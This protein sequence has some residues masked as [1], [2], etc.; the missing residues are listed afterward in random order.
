M[1]GIAGGLPH[2]LSPGHKSSIQFVSRTASGNFTG[3]EGQ[4]TAAFAPPDQAG[5]AAAS[6]SWRTPARSRAL[7]Q[8]VVAMAKDSHKPCCV[9]SRPEGS[10]SDSS[11]DRKIQPSQTEDGTEGMIPIEG[12]AFKMGTDSKEGFAADGEG[13][14]REVRVNSFYVDRTTVTNAQFS[15]FVKETGYKTEAERLGWSFVFHHFLPDNILKKDPPFPPDTPWWR[16]IKGARWDRPE[17]RG[18]HIRQRM[19]HPV[20]H[21]SW[22][23]G[24]AYC[25]WAGKRLPTEAEW[26]YAARGG[27]EQK[28]YPWGDELVPDGE[29]RCNIWQ[30]AFPD[31]N[32]EEDGFTGTAPAQ[33]FKPNGYG[34]YNVSGNVW[35]WCL[36]WFGAYYPL[37][38][39]SDNP[40]G[41]ATGEAKVIRGGSYLCHRSYCNRYRVA[42]RT[43]NTPDSST[44]NMGF[45]CVKDAD[46]IG[47]EQRTK[48][49]RQ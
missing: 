42:A 35:E 2:C 8:T 3:S 47:S 30:G 5:V 6:V 38:M 24:L 32:S 33:S 13:P 9:A 44:G 19:D 26:E 4:A 40:A 49:S 46:A 11:E 18:S 48:L 36:D 22:N 43:A 7:H 29:H 1:P 27:L 37:L 41:P 45:R 23:D 28:L 39:I 25:T 16:G 10:K 15:K 14:V 17:G 31:H 34:L 12:G 20:V 21:V